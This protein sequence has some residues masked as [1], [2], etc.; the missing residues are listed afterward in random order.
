MS[1]Y[2]GSKYLNEQLTSLNNQVGVNLDV[3]VNDDGS[4]DNTML[5]LKYWKRRGLISKISISNRIGPTKSFLN[6][7]A[8]CSEDHFIAFSDQDDVWDSRKLIEQIQLMNHDAPMIVFCSRRF[9]DSNGIE[10][11]HS[12]VL[13]KAPTF[14]NALIENVA[15]GNTILLN[16][17]AAFLIN[18]FP[19]PRIEHYDSWIY[20]LISCF[21][22]CKYLPLALV[23]YRIHRNNTVGIRK[24]NLTNFYRAVKNYMNQARYFSDSI[25][26]PKS[27]LNE[28]SLNLMLSIENA[29]NPFAKIKNIYKLKLQR[30][31]KLELFVFKVLLFFYRAS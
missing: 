23:D 22:I 18:S 10:R 7:L 1:T 25:H 13:S 30:Q 29:S 5:I 21:G 20:L 11:G 6:L 17:K 19:A 16:R 12:K 15:P 28:T 26:L 2:N 8:E 31:S 24:V 14:Q 4:S 3:R 27:V 9:I